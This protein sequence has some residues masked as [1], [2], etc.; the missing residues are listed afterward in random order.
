LRDTDGLAHVD[1]PYCDPWVTCCGGTQ[2][3]SVVWSSNTTASSFTENTWNLGKKANGTNI[4][5]TG[6]GI[7]TVSFNGELLFPLPSWQQGINVPPSVNDNTTRGRGIPDIAGYANGYN[8]TLYGNPLNK[9]GTSETAPLYA[10]LIARINATLGFNVGYLNPTLYSLAKTAVFRDIHDGISNAW[11]FVV[12]KSNP[13]Q[14]LTAPGYTSVLGWDACTGLGVVDGTQ[15]IQALSAGSITP[16]FYFSISKNTYGHDE[17]SDTLNWPQAFSLIL[18]GVAPTQVT[19]PPQFS[20]T[21][22]AISGLTISPSNTTPWPVIELGGSANSLQRISYPYDIAFTSASLGSFPAVG[23]SLQLSLT[24]GVETSASGFGSPTTT[25]QFE[26]VGGADPNFVNVSQQVQN[27]PYLSQDLRV[28]TVIPGLNASPI[29]GVGSPPVFNT[30]TVS[31]FYNTDA[32]FRYI[33]NVINYLSQN[34]SDPGGTDPFT[35]LLP[36]T[37]GLTGDTSTFPYTL[38]PANQQEAYPN[39]NF[40]IARVRLSGSVGSSAANVSVFFRL[41]VTVSND[42]DYQPATT[43]ATGPQGTVQVAPLIAN[44]GDPQT[45]PFFA[46]GNYEPNADYPANYDDYTA[47]GFNNQTIKINSTSGAWAYFGCYLN[48]YNPFNTV[49]GIAINSLLK[50]T[51]HCLVAQISFVDTPITT[52]TSTANCGQL[53]QRNLQ[54]TPSDNPGPAESHRVPQTFD[55]RPSAPF[56]RNATNLLNIPDELFIDWGN[57]PAGSRA[58][59]YWPQA[60]AT[61]I[62]AQASQLY[63]TH[64]LTAPDPHTLACSAHGQ[65]YIPIP[66]GSGTNFAGLL[67]VD[68]PRTVV[69][70]QSFTIVVHRL[71]TKQGA[72]APPPVQVPQLQIAHRGDTPITNWR[73]LAG[74]FAITIPVA[75]PAA[76]LQSEM[77][78]LA[79]F[80]WR[81]SLM[82]PTNRWYPVL[83]RYIGIV[84][85]RL[86]GIGGNPASVAPSPYGAAPIPIPF[87]PWP[88]PASGGEAG[89]TGKVSGIIYDRFGD[90]EGFFLTT[91]CGEERR[92][93]SR[94]TEIE[95]LVRFAWA[96]RVDITVLVHKRDHHCP[97]SIIL[98]RKPRPGLVWN[99]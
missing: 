29:Q 49:D 73:Y 66:T 53:A 98:R 75:T 31:E 86:R 20:G 19:S 21:F 81:L 71:T 91:E 84:E 3:S 10:G 62:I 83:L 89:Y 94:E 52:G 33:Q 25:A 74:S 16:A 77:D 36:L 40:A 13:Q 58:S 78:T 64:Q 97:V 17:V 37:G 7:S 2:L 85:S 47:G 43:Y 1:Y 38:N 79:I 95:E 80:K 61:E 45:I 11:T 63:P 18:D 44:E 59:I 4:A 9:G 67:T 26:L 39:Y 82:S 35:T 15:L 93:R 12:P 70:G 69:A 55:M 8:I 50:G 14:I 87:G 28:F 54:I 48:V 6:G 5:A 65:T 68:L 23:S 51:H 56:N 42:T 96:D 34:Y 90:F 46:T 30:T 76:I 24:A 60:S 27:P 22:T 41:F 32:A 57:V 72:P 88:A 92:F 99:A